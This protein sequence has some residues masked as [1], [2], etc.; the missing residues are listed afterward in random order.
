MR[1]AS[2]IRSIV[3]G[4]PRTHW[5]VRSVSFIRRPGWKHWTK[6]TSSFVPKGAWLALWAAAVALLIAG[7]VALV[8]CAASANLARPGQFG[9]HVGR[10]EFQHLHA[11]A[12]QQVGGHDRDGRGI[13]HDALHAGPR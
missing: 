8:Q 7:F 5:A 3:V 9:L 1:F 2:A 4:R 11:R 13:V 6:K 12:L 10:R